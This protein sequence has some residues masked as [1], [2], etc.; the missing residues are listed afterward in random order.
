MRFLPV[1]PEWVFFH[2]AFEFTEVYSN[3]KNLTI[4]IVSIWKSM[5]M[6]IRIPTGIFPKIFVSLNTEK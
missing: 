4:N 1:P 5:G 3:E 6:S 2:P